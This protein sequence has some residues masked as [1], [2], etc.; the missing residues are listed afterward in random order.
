M[1]LGCRG[2]SQPRT[3]VGPVVDP[4]TARARVQRVI[5]TQSA[6]DGDGA[7]VQRSF[8]NPQLRN[9]DPFVLL[10]DFDVRAP[11]GFPMHPHLGLEA[12]TTR[13]RARSST[14]RGKT[15][16]ATLRSSSSS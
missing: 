10:D 2:K 9:L 15:S 11:A 3:E 1:L 6:V 7:T 5:E 8:P 4:T 14:S 16:R 12:R 13:A